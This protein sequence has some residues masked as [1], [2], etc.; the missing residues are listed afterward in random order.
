[1]RYDSNG[2]SA[3]TSSA[4]LKRLRL[5]CATPRPSVV[6]YRA[7]RAARPAVAEEQGADIRAI[8]ITGD[9]PITAAA[10]AAELGIVAAAVPA[11]TGGELQRMDD[12]GMQAA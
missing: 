9:H 5:A 12:T 4:W 1:M 8:M 7:V 10:I 3:K 11:L 6:R 2:L